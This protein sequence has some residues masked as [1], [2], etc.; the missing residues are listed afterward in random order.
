MTERSR[1]D[2]AVNIFGWS[3]TRSAATS[4]AQARA[5][6]NAAAMTSS[7]GTAALPGA[8]TAARIHRDEIPLAVRILRKAHEYQ[9]VLRLHQ[10]PVSDYRPDEFAAVLQQRLGAAAAVEAN[11]QFAPFL[12]EEIE[13]LEQAV[14]DLFRID[15]IGDATQLG[16][17]GRVL[18][19]DLHLR[20]G[21][22]EAIQH[23]GSVAV[24][25]DR[26]IEATS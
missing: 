2:V 4:S 14:R 20:L 25:A 21:H 17:V 24:F 19:E 22:S 6:R 8:P 10:H 13:R 3:I 26:A 23:L 7:V 9:W 15:L 16:T 1:E 11:P 5:A 18:L 12:P